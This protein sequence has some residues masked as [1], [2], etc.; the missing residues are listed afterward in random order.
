VLVEKLPPEEQIPRYTA[1]Y[2]KRGIINQALS[3]FDE[4]VDD[5]TRMLDVARTNGL[6]DTEHAALNAMG[7]T[8]FWAHRMD[9]MAARID[10]LKPVFESS[11]FRRPPE[12]PR[13]MAGTKPESDHLF[14]LGS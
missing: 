13:N 10:E 1:L 3:R 9:E 11:H 6:R 2:Q 7:T 14:A 8:L 12:L 5:F 4:A